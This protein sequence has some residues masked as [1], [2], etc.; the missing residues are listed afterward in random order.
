MQAFSR[1]LFAVTVCGFFSASAHGVDVTA[2]INFAGPSQDFS[3][4]LEIKPG[5][6]INV[7][8]DGR[9]H[10]FD[11][12]LGSSHL[13]IDIPN[14]T[15]ALSLNP[16]KTVLVSDPTGSATIG[17]DNVTAGNA[18]LANT[19]IDFRNGATW[20]FAF[21]PIVFNLD[22]EAIGNVGLKLDIA[23]SITAFTFTQDAGSVVSAGPFGGLPGDLVVSYN[24]TVDARAQDVIGG[25]DF[26]LGEIASI[27]D[28]TISN[29]NL[30]AATTLTEVPGLYPRDLKTELAL[31]LT[32][33]PSDF[34]TFPFSVTDSVSQNEGHGAGNLDL[35]I[36]FII[37]AELAISD[38]FYF[39][40]DTL[41]GVII[42][43]PST[44]TL[45][46]FG[47]FGSVFI[48]R[49]RRTR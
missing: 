23:G 7:V 33:L 3:L 43:E 41:T 26:D 8:G 38:L 46:G 28:T 5:S 14:Q 47:V 29:Q 21:N 40:N 27:S 22:I 6:T 12:F 25:V 30:P 13:D 24:L 18:T 31:D 32:G 39:L 2:G 44:L 11:T 1:F 37:D 19:V 48:R 16:N 45:L 15:V 10:V 42:P 4:G 9:Y 35:N 34:L 49:R 36:N 17:F 20:N